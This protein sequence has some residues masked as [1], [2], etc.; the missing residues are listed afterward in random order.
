[1][2]DSLKQVRLLRG[3]RDGQ[4]K[5]VVGQAHVREDAAGVV[6]KVQKGARLQ[7]EDPWAHLA[8]HGA[9][10]QVVE[11]TRYASQRGRTSML[12]RRRITTWR[13]SGRRSGW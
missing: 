13:L 5:E 12:H 8:E 7:V 1:M 3:G 11:Q 9:G 2:V 10:T 6:V 4:T